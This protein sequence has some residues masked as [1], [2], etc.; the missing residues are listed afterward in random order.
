M[1]ILCLSSVSSSLK[2]AISRCDQGDEVQLAG[3]AVGHRL[4][5]V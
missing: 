1:L 4:S 5:A 2:F 3:G